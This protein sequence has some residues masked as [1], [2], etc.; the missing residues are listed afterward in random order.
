MRA[1]DTSDC[2]RSPPRRI[3]L[4]RS[5]SSTVHEESRAQWR[6]RSP[7]ATEGCA[8]PATLSGLPWSGF[9]VGVDNPCE[10]LTAA[11]PPGCFHQPVV[12]LTEQDPI[13]VFGVRDEH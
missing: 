10:L 6:R 4:G 13:H 3:Q 9:G 7:E 1:W 5:T 2:A 12:M 11:L 8:A